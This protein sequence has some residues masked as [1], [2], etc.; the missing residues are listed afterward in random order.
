MKQEIDRDKVKR[1]EWDFKQVWV[2]DP[3]FSL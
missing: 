1:G 3:L 2:S